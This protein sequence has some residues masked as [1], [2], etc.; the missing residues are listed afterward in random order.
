MTFCF[1][2]LNFLQFFASH[3]EFLYLDYWSLVYH[4]VPLMT[5]EAVHQYMA[6]RFIQPAHTLPHK[7]LFQLLQKKIIFPYTLQ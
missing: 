3:H 7:L 1:L 5:A 6:H 2:S 4:I